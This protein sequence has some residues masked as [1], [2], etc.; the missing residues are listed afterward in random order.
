MILDQQFIKQIE[1][2]LHRTW[3]AIAYDLADTS[4]TS[5]NL[6]MTLEHLYMYGE[7]KGEAEKLIRAARKEHGYDK[8]QQF[9]ND[10]IK[11]CL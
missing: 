1:P 11:L 2:A 9:L 10:Q 6:V 7:D 5:D 8:V 4:D 3:A